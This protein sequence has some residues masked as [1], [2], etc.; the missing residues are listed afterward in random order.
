MRDGIGTRVTTWWWIGAL[1]LGGLVSTGRADERDGK[2]LYEAYCAS[3]HGA[4]GRG[5]GR[6]ADLFSPPPR[7]LRAG[8]LTKYG[9][10]E[11]I[12]RI[13]HGRPL[14]LTRDPAALRERA[15]DIE[16]LVAHLRRLPT[17]DWREVE[18]GQELYVDRC[19]VCHGP[20]GHPTTVLPLGVTKAPRDLSDPAYQRATTDGT[21]VERVRHGHE[22][23]PAIPGFEVRENRAALLAY[24]RLLSP[25]YESYSR[26]CAGCHGDDGRGPE[27]DWPS[28]KRP[29]VVFDAAYFKKKD[30]EVLRRDVWHMT[31][32]EQPQMPHMRRVLRPREV[33]AILTFLRSLPPE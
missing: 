13:R 7:N 17:I 25:G 30:P 8:V 32:D 1:V 10:D 21:L 19:E 11:L 20:F 22:G 18:R 12:E 3:C 24:L 4:E 2:V 33:R 27:V 29:T 31:Q 5:D 6:D 14:D 16:L 28:E 23:M 9:D 26:F 15:A